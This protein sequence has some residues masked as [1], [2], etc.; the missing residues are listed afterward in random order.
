MPAKAHR[1]EEIIGRRCEA[2]VVLAQDPTMAEA[3]RLIAAS[4]Q[5]FHRWSKECGGLM[6][7]RAR[8]MKVLERRMRGFVLRSWT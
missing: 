4:E 7:D 6:A 3:C 1:L 5:A 2:E 8:R